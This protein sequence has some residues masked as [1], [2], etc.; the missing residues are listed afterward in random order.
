MVACASNSHTVQNAMFFAIEVSLIVVLLLI[1]DDTIMSIIL[2]LT[3]LV[4]LYMLI[5]ICSVYYVV[6]L[7]LFWCFYWDSTI[8]NYTTQLIVT[9]FHGKPDIVVFEGLWIFKNYLQ[10][11]YTWWY[12]TMNWWSIVKVMWYQVIWN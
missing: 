3:L 9:I 1:V 11:S 6:I 10:G 8:N 7:W 2:W 12:C 4:N 5:V